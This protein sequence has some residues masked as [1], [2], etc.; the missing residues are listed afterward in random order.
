VSSLEVSVGK[1]VLSVSEKRQDY[2]ILIF[3]V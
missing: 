2:L 3:R 1:G